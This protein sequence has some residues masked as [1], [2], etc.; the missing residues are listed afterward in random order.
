[1]K[2]G[3]GS[4]KS[5]QALV[6]DA[7]AGDTEAFAQLIARYRDAASAVAYSYLGGFDDVQDA[8][9][10]AFVHAYCNLR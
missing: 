10:D 3:N 1:M 7:L 9:Q 2:T 4:D 8:V 6:E 5:T